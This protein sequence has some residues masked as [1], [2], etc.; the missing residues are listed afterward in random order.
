VLFPVT[1]LNDQFHAVEVPV[2]ISVNCI[3][4][5][6]LPEVASTVKSAIGAT[7]TAVTVTYLLRVRELDPL[8]FVTVRFTVYV[9]ALV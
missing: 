4:S 7:G 2:D 5:G 3:A 6:A 9:P 8:E 1:F